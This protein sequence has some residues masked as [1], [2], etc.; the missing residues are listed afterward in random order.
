METVESTNG[1]R[2]EV[3]ARAKP[4]RIPERLQQQWEALD[5]QRRL[6]EDMNQS[7]RDALIIFGAANTGVVFVLLRLANLPEATRGETIAKVF[8]WIYAIAAFW[9]L[10]DA[11]R[12]LRWRVS[13]SHLDSLREELAERGYSDQVLLALFPLGVKRASLEQRQTAWQNATGE[14]VSAEL[15]QLGGFVSSVFDTKAALL[16]RLYASLSVMLPL[17][18]VAVAACAFVAGL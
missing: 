6:L 14:Q 4:L 1:T 9:V 13:S 12:L 16:R 3:N 2:V 5:L 15:A 17:A 18:A 8:V 11:V 10:L 7:V